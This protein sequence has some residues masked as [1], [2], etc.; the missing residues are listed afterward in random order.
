MG[1]K[2]MKCS[3]CAGI[4]LMS[5]NGKEK[6]CPYCDS[7]FIVKE[8]MCESGKQYVANEHSNSEETGQHITEIVRG[9]CGKSGFESVYGKAGYSLG[10][11][12][13]YKKAQTNFGIGKSEDIYLIFDATILGSCKKGF[14]ICTT[15]LYYCSDGKDAYVI[16]WDKFKSVGIRKEGGSIFI[17]SAEFLTAGDSKELYTI[18]INIQENL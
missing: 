14:A 8:N 7:V 10:N 17:G 6:I 2:Q 13:K 16:R 15:G 12:S 3:N 9:I 5:A 1:D 18:L 11:Y 4:L